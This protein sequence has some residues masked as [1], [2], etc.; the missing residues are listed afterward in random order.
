MESKVRIWVSEKG[1]NG[2]R[3]FRRYPIEGLK[4]ARVA[5]HI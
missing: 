5:L 3:E 4:T 2:E 1:I